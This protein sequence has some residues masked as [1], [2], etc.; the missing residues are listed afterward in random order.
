MT[1]IVHISKVT[2]IAGSEGH[3]LR[4]LPGLAE[5]GFE[6]IMLILED[7]QSPAT[8]FCTILESAN[9]RVER[10]PIHYHL[11]FSCITAL[12]SK[13]KELQPEIVHTH[14]LHA[15]LYGLKAAEDVNIPVRVS[16]RH[17]NDR[18]RRNWFV[19]QINRYS[20]RSANRVIA[21]SEAVA[22]FV[23]DIEG[24]P[25]HKVQII[26][27]GLEAP[28]LESAMPARQETRR[29]LGY[30]EDQH[31]VGFF[32]RLV[33]QKGVD[34]LIEAMKDVMRLHPEAKLLI[35]GD[36]PDR[37][38]LTRQAAK[39]GIG[40]AVQ[41]AGWVDQANR[42][43]PACDMI[44]VPSRWEGFGLVTLEA[45]GWSLPLVA[46]C[47]SSL[48]EII[49]DGETGLLVSPEDPSALATAISNLLANS[50]TAR[51]YGRAGYQRLRD[52]FSVDSM[53][54]STEALYQDLI[55]DQRS[56]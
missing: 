47:T 39:S 4:L 21:I 19:K 13:L 51:A 18:F 23:R 32:G 45:M 49:V 15:D 33:Y 8:R 55:E 44:I 24:I 56:H 3:L 2:G 43:M 46:S 53:V 41:F 37:P 17:N 14:L 27:Y 25:A 50:D 35:V 28:L 40:E 42:L 26:R 16:S 34:V 36:G 22:Q 9:V 20:M 12:R 7:P 10:I 52:R 11:D 48:P 30:P 54:S 5:R 1:R 6:P 31:V 38:S 29:E